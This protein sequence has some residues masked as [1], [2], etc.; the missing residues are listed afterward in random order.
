MKYGSDI[1]A[2]ND[3]KNLTMTGSGE[4]SFEE[5]T[6]TKAGTY[7]FEIAETSGNQ[8]GYKYD[9]SKWTLTVNVV[10]ENGELKATPSYTK[11][12]DSS[13]THASFTNTYSVTPDAFTPQVEKQFSDDSVARPNAKDFIFKLTADEQNPAGGAFTGYVDEANTGIALEGTNTIETQV[14]GS[15]TG[16]FDTI[17]FTKAGTYKFRIQEEAGSD[18]GYTY[19]DAVW[20]LTVQVD[21]IGGAL[22]VTNNDVTY[23]SNDTTVEP[24]NEK[25]VFVNEYHYI[26]SIIINKEVL[27]GNAEYETNDM[28]YAG[29]F[30]KVDNT[31]NGTGSET[32]NIS[33]EI[34]KN[35]VVDNQ[36]VESGV[37][38]LANN[39]SVEVYVPLGGEDQTEAITYYV[40]ETD[41]EGHPLVSFDEDGNAVYNQPFAY[42]ISSESTGEDGTV[43]GRGEV[44]VTPDTA[45]AHP[46]VTITNRATSVS[47]E[48]RD[49]SGNPLTGAVLEL[50]KQADSVD[51][52]VA[53][54]E[55]RTKAGNGDILLETW[56]SDGTPH[57]LTAELAVG[58]TYYLRE[59]E[60][61][62][63]YVQAADILF[64]V[65]NGDPITLVME[66]EN[67]A[68]VLGQIQVTKRLSAI[69]ETTFDNI[70]LVAEDATVYVGLF[71]DAQGEHPYGEDYVKEIHIQDASSGT[72]TFDNLPSGTYYVFETQ[73]DGTVI[74]YGELQADAAGS[75]AGFICAG[76]GSNGGVKEITLNPDTGAP[77]G[78]TELGNVYY[79]DLPDGFAYQG[80]L[81]ITKAV[82]KDGA[83]ADS[84][85]TFYAG[86]FTS[87]TETVPYK[88]VALE[89]NGTVTVEVPLGGENGMDPVTYYIYETDADGN[90]IDKNSFAYTVSGEGTVDLDV[91][92][93]TAGRTIINTM[94][95]D[96]DTTRT[97]REKNDSDTKKISTDT[98][99]K[100]T[101]TNRRTSS[102]KTGDDTRVGL[103]L[104]FFAAAAVGIILTLRKRKEDKPE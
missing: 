77:E 51:A 31:G 3:V 16:A 80:E 32:G 13:V 24:N 79:G 35:V 75:G 95:S 73:Q 91:D 36:T 27:R 45:G 60:V 34:V 67:Q 69:D 4:S 97:V 44:Y 14:N 20:M 41:A 66:D 104:L 7:T 68:G 76:D 61:P 12:G 57:E 54:D 58:G 9:S 50:W 78:S 15:G 102:S 38:Q 1:M 56:T 83:P 42:E 98:S 87:E 47:I 2:V 8:P 17:T 37:V 62:A 23:Q 63:G 99:K 86:I 40:F 48:K 19:D 10:D 55:D 21:D 18:L 71:T 46:E 64:T 103:Y 30:R 82:M 52:G 93:T 70:D 53:A 26:S 22:Q 96:P 92:N 39:D 100:S 11:A 59:A 49:I 89:N 88:V 90:K 81:M 74:P 5:L 6:F 94:A 85:D 29:I 72:V 65:E 43:N 84:S 101:G 25:A 33:Y 28:F